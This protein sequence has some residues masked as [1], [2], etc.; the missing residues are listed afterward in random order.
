[1]NWKGYGRKRLWPNLR[2]YPGIC[3]EGLRKTTKSLTQA[4][5][6]PGRDS[7]PGLSGE[8]LDPERDEVSEGWGGGGMHFEELNNLYSSPNIIRM[9]ES[10]R[11]FYYCLY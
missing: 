7:N 6:S 10:R 3:M 11:C 1:M 9:I 5:R 8:Y 2:Y 4:I